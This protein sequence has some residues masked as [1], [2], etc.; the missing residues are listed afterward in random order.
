[1]PSQRSFSNMEDD[2]IMDTCEVEPSQVVNDLRLFR[3][4]KQTSTQQVNEV[5][6]LRSQ[7]LYLQ[8]QV[9][10]LTRQLQSCSLQ[11][12][13]IFHHFPRLP[14][15]LRRKIWRYALPAPRIMSV[16][17]LQ[18]SP[19]HNPQFEPNHPPPM[20]LQVCHEAREVALENYELV[21]AARNPAGIATAVEGEKED[22]GG[23]AF[24]FNFRGDTLCFT[25]ETMPLRIVLFLEDM[26]PAEVC[27]VRYLAVGT[28]LPKDIMKYV[29]QFHG[30]E[31]FSL[32]LSDP[33]VAA[34]R[35]KFGIV[36]ADHRSIW[37]MGAYWNHELTSWGR[38][39]ALIRDA[40]EEA[41]LMSG[42]ECRV[43]KVEFVYAVSTDEGC[44][45][46]CPGHE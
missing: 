16:D 33:R 28:E 29:T 13:K 44:C 5:F 14:P 9:I 24:H 30:L 37:V 26:D 40:F 17:F 20:L 36:E 3:P 15:E 11:P 25:R 23:A 21:F 32:I 45:R 4:N 42:G 46:D 1:M 7:N 18:R 34:P 22:R 35:G 27:R 43:P 8:D 38:M 10:N 19:Q 39:E 2:D 12:P 31:V 6:A 41:R